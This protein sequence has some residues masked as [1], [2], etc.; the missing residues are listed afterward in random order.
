[1][2][3]NDRI[4]AVIL[5]VVGAAGIWY[6]SNSA[7]IGTRDMPLADP[8]SPKLGPSWVGA[9][10]NYQVTSWATVEQT[11]QVGSTAEAVL[12]AYLAFFKLDTT[13]VP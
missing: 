1:M 4:L 2:H 7:P 11:T 10:A 6:L 5:A 3:K 8:K 9:T 12:R 13:A